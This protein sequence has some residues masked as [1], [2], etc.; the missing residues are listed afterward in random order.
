MVQQHFILNDVQ[1]VHI[2]NNQV[3]NGFFFFFSNLQIILRQWEHCR[4]HVA[5]SDTSIKRGTI[6]Y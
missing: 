3:E 2:Y 6:Q 4:P 1:Q 5:A